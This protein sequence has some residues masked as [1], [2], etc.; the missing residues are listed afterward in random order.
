MKSPYRAI[1]CQDVGGLDGVDASCR[2]S[3]AYG[4]QGSSDGNILRSSWLGG[5]VPVV[6]ALVVVAVV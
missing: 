1:S 6:V 5:L 3:T 4:L 2:S